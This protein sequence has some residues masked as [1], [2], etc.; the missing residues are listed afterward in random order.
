M[1]LL[2][3][4]PNTIKKIFIYSYLRWKIYYAACNIGDMP[5]KMHILKI[6]RVDHTKEVAI[7]I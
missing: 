5:Y 7:V 4:V 6:K 3:I 1:Q 2:R